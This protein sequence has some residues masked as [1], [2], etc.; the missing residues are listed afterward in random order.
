MIVA[1]STDKDSVSLHFGRCPAFTLIKM[2]E[3]K[4]MDKEMIANPGHQPGFLPDFLSERGVECIICGGMGPRAQNLFI[5]KGIKVILG[6]EGKVDEVIGKLL[7]GEL[8]GGES[9]CRPGEGRGY[10]IPRSECSHD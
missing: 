3:G 1:I 6:V 8:K 7:K 5:Q 4:L 10:G 9:L 2:E